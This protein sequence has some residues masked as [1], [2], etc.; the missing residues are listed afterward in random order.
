MLQVPAALADRARRH[1]GAD[2]QSWAGHLPEII[3]AALQDWSLE[4][5]AQLP[6]GQQLSLL[7]AVTTSCGQPAVLKAS[8]P[9]AGP[10]R[11]A[12]ALAQW[13][14]HGAVTLL[15]ADPGRGLL[16][17]EQLTASRSLAAEPGAA[18]LPVAAD[19]LAQ[20]WVPPPPRHPFP[21][22]ADR[23]RQWLAVIPGRHRQLGRP[24]ETELLGAA[25]AATRSLAAPSRRPLLLHG[26]FHRGNVLASGR[27][28]WLAIDP[29]PAAGDPEYDVAD[30][31]A[32]LLDE[33]IGQPAA[34]RRLAA[35]LAGL[36]QAVPE[37]E[38]RRVRD[39]MLAKRVILALDN[40]AAG[41]ERDSDGEW[42]L[43]F[44][45]LLVSEPLPVRQAKLTGVHRLFPITPPPRS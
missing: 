5:Q 26:D 3:T 33:H 17:L 41:G 21:E 20:L 16:L 19:L 1:L 35:V 12:A 39:W 31:A 38:L 44:A 2:G 13:A 25:V 4:P 22:S 18:A 28:G 29:C 11:E 8:Y 6:L 14:G 7:L 40:L 43:A 24:F 42:D 36:G 37:L 9:D 32:D 30:L 45:R 15:R 34:G 23:A 10:R 27:A